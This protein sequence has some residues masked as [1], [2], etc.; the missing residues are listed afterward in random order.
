MAFKKNLFDK[1]PALIWIVLVG[2]FSG[3]TQWPQYQHSDPFAAFAAFLDQQ[4]STDT[5]LA[6]T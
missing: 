6:S 1:N 2:W 4:S 3:G 5:R